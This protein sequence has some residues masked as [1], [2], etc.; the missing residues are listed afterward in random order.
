MNARTTRVARKVA[1][2]GLAVAPPVLALSWWEGAEDLT[3]QLVLARA[4][5]WSAAL[6]VVLGLLVGVWRWRRAAP[7]RQLARQAAPGIAIAIA[8]TAAVMWAVPPA[9]RVQFDETSLAGT[10]Q[11][12]HRHR[13]AMMTTGALPQ[14]GVVMPIENTV[15]KRPPLF[16]FLVSLLHDVRGYHV[17]NAFAVNGALLALALFVA[18]AA[19]RARLGAIAAAAAPLLLLAVPLTTIVATSAGFE[20]LAATLFGI[21]LLAALDFAQRPDTVRWTTLLG[22]GVLFAQ[23]RQE[24]LAALAIVLALALWRVRGQWRPD[25]CAWLAAA[26]CPT[27]LTPGIVLLVYSRDPRFYP[28]AGGQPLVSLQHGLDHVGPFLAATF[29]PALANPFPGVLAIAGLAA[30]LLRGLRR[31]LCWHDAV[32]VLPVLAVTAAALLWF[33]GDVRESIAL[34]LFVPFTWLC[35]LS[36]LL[37]LLRNGAR[38]PAIVLPAVLLLGAAL[39]LAALRVDTVRSGAAFPRGDKVEVVEAIDRIVARLSPDPAHTLWITVAAQ[40]LI[41]TGHAA[42]YP[43]RFAWHAE[44]AGRPWLRSLRIFV[45]ETPLDA[46][47]APGLGDLR[48]L[49]RAYGS[50]VVERSGG[51][52]PLTV[53]RLRP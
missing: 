53:H 41:V 27:L 26:V 40:R 1:V 25:R 15:D 45:L 30:W 34:R 17:E 21:V 8:L 52:V 12:M 13:L 32:V 51:D 10:A 14:D 20:L 7:A 28:E 19:V 38:A 4:L 18:F 49:L 37:L 29:A 11:N 6:L 46:A 50:D 44:Q 42:L 48:E 35:A 39:A 36:P 9:M 43:Q 3:R 22:G 47:M 31:R 5:Y 23:S 33:I 24:S 16:P 2:F